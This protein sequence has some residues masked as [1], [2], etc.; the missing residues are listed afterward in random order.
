MEVQHAELIDE[1]FQDP[2]SKGLA[3]CS[4]AAED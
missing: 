1:E 4:H 3:R 2:K